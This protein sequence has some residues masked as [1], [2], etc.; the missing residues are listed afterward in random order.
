[1][2]YYG[3]GLGLMKRVNVLQAWGMALAVFAIFALFSA[4]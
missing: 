2:I 3:F 1:V 4:A